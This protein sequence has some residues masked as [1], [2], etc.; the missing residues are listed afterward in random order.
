MAEEVRTEQEDEEETSLSKIMIALMLFVAAVA[1]EHVPALQQGSA[2]LAENEL[3]AKGVPVAVMALYLVSYL[4]CGL[5]VLKRALWNIFHGDVFDEE[6]LMSVASVGALCL[7]QYPEAVAVML[8]YQIG[9]YLE[10]KA[11]GKSK[12]SISELMNIRPDTADVIRDGKLV[13]VK[14]ETVQVGE[15]IVV[16]AGERVALDGVVSKGKSFVDT[17]ALT[18][19]SVPREIVEGSE[20]MAGFVNTSGTIELKV[21]KVYGESAVAR[22]LDLVQNASSKKAKSEQF[23]TK[24]SR[25]YTP[26]VCGAAVLLAVIP[27]LVTMLSM[28]L[29]SGG[30]E[31]PAI[32]ASG[33]GATGTA[34]F[35]SMKQVWHTWIYRALLFLVVSCPCALVISV[36]LS[37]FAGI[38]AASRKGILIKGAGYIEKLSQL[39]TVVF[40]KT[41]TLTK[42]VF[43][44]TAVHPVDGAKVSAQELVAIATH[45]EFYSNHPISRSLKAAHHCAQCGKIIIGNTEEISG[46]GLKTMLDGRQ[47]LA[48]NMKLMEAQQVDGVVPCAEHDS[49]TV[50]HVAIDGVYAGHIVISDEVKD[51]AA[52]AIAELKKCGVR[53]TVLL[54]GDSENAGEAAGRLLKIDRVF[55]ELLPGDKV[56]QVELLLDQKEKRSGT[57]AFVGDGINDAPVLTRS[58]VGIAMGGLGSDAAIEAADVVIMDDQVSKVALAVRLSKK[59]MRVVYE[60]IYFALG[61]KALIMVLGAFGLV[62]MW[63]A[64]FGDVGVTLIAVLNSMRLLMKQRQNT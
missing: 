38:G 12:R 26:A 55:S 27:P 45:A 35:V 28:R 41:G 47:V 42:G 44:V 13:Q 39:Q 63:M 53:E 50:V 48:G 51:D 17:S 2:L 18:G 43:V 7:G 59:I 14:A 8:F 20:V 40:D 15:T 36:P 10:D 11:V 24:F 19:E 58:D 32:I 52:R 60:N 3:L 37:F 25:I 46:Q 9:E 1:F 29:G 56:A 54:T 16:K 4:L 6:F 22:I 62:N 23:I 57:L 49:G 61:V 21:S 33:A 30:G 5:G 34:A 64:V 31:G